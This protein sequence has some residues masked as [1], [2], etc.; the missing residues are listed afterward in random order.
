[1]NVDI[2]RMKEG[3]AHG[4]YPDLVKNSSWQG[5]DWRKG[6]SSQQEE[7]VPDLLEDVSVMKEKEEC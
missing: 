1:M 2:R 7:E 5:A 6:V 3:K 4:G